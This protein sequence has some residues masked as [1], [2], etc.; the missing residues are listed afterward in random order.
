MKI[1]KLYLK[2][3]KQ[4]NEDA[5]VVNEEAQVFAAIDG[6]TGLGGTPG[7]LASQ[8]F[9]KQLTEMKHYSSLYTTIKNANETLGRTMVDYYEANI[10]KIA[11]R[12]LREIP[13]KQRSTTGLATIK[14]HAQKS[15]LEYVHTGDCMLFLQFK[16]EEVYSVTH[17]AI[18]YFDS[19]AVEEMVRLRE[20]NPEISLKDVREKVNPIL[21]RN[22]GLLNTPE[23]YG[24]LDGSENALAYLSHGRVPL[25][26]V[27]GILLV[28]DGLLLPQKIEEERGWRQTAKLAFD[29]G[30][31]GL[32]KEVEKRES[33]DAE[34]R[35]YPR[36]KQRDD[37][38]GILLKW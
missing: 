6:A 28:S 27:K 21:L 11:S 38:T 19:L 12:S 36:L 22:R 33:D 24:I 18:Q 2:G 16:N 25:H 37:K 10:G 7:Y 34:C 3:D 26:Q 14:L 35:I 8:T 17:D 4:V 31:D 20:K 32:V 30:L 5:C 15:M 29:H 9:H 1:Q 23:G 13:K